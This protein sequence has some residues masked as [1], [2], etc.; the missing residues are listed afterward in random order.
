MLGLA[1]FG[2]LHNEVMD[3]WSSRTQTR[4]KAVAVRMELQTFSRHMSSRLQIWR[5]SSEHDQFKFFDDS[6]PLE[7]S[8]LCLLTGKALAIGELEM[9]DGQWEMITLNDDN[10]PL[11][12]DHVPDDVLTRN[13]FGTYFQM[14]QFGDDFGVHQENSVDRALYVEIFVEQHRQHRLSILPFRLEF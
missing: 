13:P 3:S 1:F 10:W 6:V 8:Q 11:L 9:N 5:T 12:F 4:E 2:L 7:T 14:E